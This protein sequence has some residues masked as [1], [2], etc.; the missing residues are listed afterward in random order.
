[1]IPTTGQ[2]PAWKLYPGKALPVGV[3]S[4]LKDGCVHGGLMDNNKR[5]TE[6][7]Q[8]LARLRSGSVLEMGFSR[9]L[10]SHYQSLQTNWYRD[11][12]GIS[13]LLA[14]LL[15][16]SSYLVELG[17]A[18][19]LS[20]TTLLL[21]GLSIVLLLSTY[22]YTRYSRRMTW[23]YWVVA[24]NT[25]V[26]V[27]TLLLMAQ[28]TAQPIKM[29]H[30]C[31][32]ILVE[33]TVFTFIRLPLNF[34]NT[35]GV[36]LMLLLGT[37]LYLDNITLEAAI[38]L[39]FFMLGGTLVSVLVAIKTERM[40]RENFLRAELLQ[41][42]KMQLRDLNDRINLESSL[43]RVTRLHNRSAFE[44][45]LLGIWSLASQQDEN[46]TLVAIN[47]EH[48]AYF[49]EQRGVECG[50]DLLREIARKIRTVLLE[51]HDLACRLSGGRFVLLF[52]GDEP[53]INRQL[54]QL[55][56]RL[57]QLTVLQ[58]YAPEAG[59]VHLSWGRATLDP[60]SDRD[61]C[62]M[63]DRIFRHLVAMESHTMTQAQSGQR[64]GGR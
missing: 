48:F 43:D 21:R 34:T 15:L 28:E 46:L 47:I 57:G 60:E 42:E 25:L 31:H 62:S 58:R 14:I 40:A 44:D 11:A 4:K 32:V 63:L 55:R 5:Y 54:E 16:A 27:S 2:A 53:R 52:S 1:M 13:S 29:M 26:L 7:T 59:S 51:R 35:L 45:K 23:K 19:G 17:T 37:A 22:I 6:A 39:L 33:V 61:P 41:L 20:A 12:I 9:D 3:D 36:V 24:V 10:E 49:N 56:A 64:Q 38:H 30:Y 50:D 8:Q 18:I